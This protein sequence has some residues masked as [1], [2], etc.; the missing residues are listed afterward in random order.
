MSPAEIL[1]GAADLI[2]RDGWCQ[3]HAMNDAG[4]MCLM[5]ALVFTASGMCEFHK[6]RRILGH[7]IDEP[8]VEWNDRPGRTKEEVITALREA[9]KMARGSHDR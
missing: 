9:A 5:Q 8:I 1:E 6:L 2:E 7:A 4:E 3:G